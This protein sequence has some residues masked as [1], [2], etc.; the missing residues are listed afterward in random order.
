MAQADVTVAQLATNVATGSNGGS[1]WQDISI[2]HTSKFSTMNQSTEAK[3]DNQSWSVNFWIGGGGGSSSSTSAG[4]ETNQA[5]REVHV[6]ISMKVTSVTVDRSS[7][8]QVCD[9]PAS[10]IIAQ[11][12]P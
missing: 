3:V 8:F 12:T 5:E 4:S 2:V 9:T 6:E 7:W 10:R 11:L 1:R